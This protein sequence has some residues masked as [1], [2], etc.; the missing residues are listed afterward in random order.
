[1]KAGSMYDNVIKYL[2]STHDTI[3]YKVIVSRDV[4]SQLKMPF[5]L[6]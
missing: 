1:M 4:E 2:K 6:L 3:L 5:R